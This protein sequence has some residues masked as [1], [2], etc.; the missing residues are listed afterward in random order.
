MSDV[1]DLSENGGARLSAT[2]GHRGENR[3]PSS[4][5]SLDNKFK[6]LALDIASRGN[7]TSAFSM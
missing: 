2:P 1:H 7:L 3:P 4:E 6:N 5:D